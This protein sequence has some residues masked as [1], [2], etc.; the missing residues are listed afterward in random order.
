[1]KKCSKK[2]NCV[3]RNAIL[4]TLLFAVLITA[5]PPA[6]NAA[7]PEW[8]FLPIDAVVTK[9]VD[10][11]E[12]MWIG[13]NDKGVFKVHKETL[14]F[15]DT[16]PFQGDFPALDKEGNLWLATFKGFVKYDGSVITE[17]LYKDYGLSDFYYTSCINIDNEGLIWTGL[18]DIL[19]HDGIGIVSF[20]GTKYTLYNSENSALPKNKNNGTTIMSIDSD[21]ENNIWA[22]INELGIA[23]FDGTEW[24]VFNDT[25]SGLPSNSVNVLKCDNT[26]NLWLGTRKGLVKF[27]GTNWTVFDTS[28]SGLFND[29]ISNL[30][31]DNSNNKW[32]STSGGYGLIKFDDTNWTYY[33]TNNSQIKWNYISRAIEIDNKSNKWIFVHDGDKYWGVNIFKEGGVILSI[34]ESKNNLKEDLIIIPNPVNDNLYLNNVD[35]IDFRFNIYDSKG[36]EILNG[37]LTENLIDVSSLPIGIYFIRVSN[38]KIFRYSRFIKN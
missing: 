8:M 37:I 31:I 26:G 25:N 34:D 14:T 21:A 23:K 24:L 30:A 12:Y 19:N 33:N 11:G 1:M 5:K 36:Q 20:D 4:F 15:V 9:F 17:Y 35:Y 3:I 10:A 6:T 28:N 2:E 27:D 22:A 38:G 13:T 18:V 7:N 16:V 32:L 29:I